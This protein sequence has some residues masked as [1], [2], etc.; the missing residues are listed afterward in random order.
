MSE[1]RPS[2][3]GVFEGAIAATVCGGCYPLA[4]YSFSFFGYAPEDWAKAWL[5][6]IFGTS[7]IAIFAF[8]GRYNYVRFRDR[9]GEIDDARTDLADDKGSSTN[10]DLI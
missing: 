6:N 3:R 2:T 8:V 1:R 5:A 9:D 4:T 10:P 7:V